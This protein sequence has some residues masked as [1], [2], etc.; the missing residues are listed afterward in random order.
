M[1]HTVC[2][3]GLRFLLHDAPAFE[4]HSYVVEGAA[5]TP[6]SRREIAGLI[7]ADSMPRLISPL[8]IRRM[9]VCPADRRTSA[10][11]YENP[12]AGGHTDDLY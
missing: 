11:R 7:G 12:P 8:N 9:I 2:L 1:H 4:A 6:G 10:V 3:P 5:S